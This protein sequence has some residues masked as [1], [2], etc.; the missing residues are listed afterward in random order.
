MQT[1]APARRETNMVRSVLVACSGHVV[2]WFDF[3]AYAFAAIHFAAVFFPAGDPTSQLLKT[4]AIFGAGFLMRPLGAWFFGRLA[5]RRGRRSALV[6]SVALMGLGSLLITVL[7]T[8]LTV[9]TP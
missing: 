3:F 4:A 2:E 6:A 9:Y 8:P 1:L 7:P 5:D